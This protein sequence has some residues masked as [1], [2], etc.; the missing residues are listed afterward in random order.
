MGRTLGGTHLSLPTHQNSQFVFY[1][2]VQLTC[3]FLSV[4]QSCVH[5]LKYQ[6]FLLPFRG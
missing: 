6:Q 1:K 5:A 2:Y 4:K 3:C